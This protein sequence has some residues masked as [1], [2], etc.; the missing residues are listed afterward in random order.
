MGH[1][2][3]SS[4][5]GIISI[6]NQYNP[7]LSKGMGAAAP[8]KLLGVLSARNSCLG[9]CQDR[10]VGSFPALNTFLLAH[11]RQR[12]F[13]LWDELVWGFNSRNSRRDAQNKPGRLK[14]A[15]TG[16]C[17]SRDKDVTR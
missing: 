5:P 3:F 7:C 4:K 14:I 16:C 2:A 1:G 17:F 12:C 13:S 10:P 8:G 9:M 11:L 15:H 6:I